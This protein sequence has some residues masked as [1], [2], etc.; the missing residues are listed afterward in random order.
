MAVYLVN[1]RGSILEILRD[2]FLCFPEGIFLS[3][4][5][6]FFSC[7]VIFKIEQL[8]RIRVYM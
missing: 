8:I 1:V 4:I 5:L 7:Q 2:Q 6:N 3:E